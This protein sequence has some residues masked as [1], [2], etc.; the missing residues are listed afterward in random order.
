[1]ATKKIAADDS[2]AVML[3][4][5]ADEYATVQRALAKALVHAL[6]VGASADEHD[7]ARLMTDLEMRADD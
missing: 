6:E 3:E 4:L 1:M 5:R 2:G 7:L